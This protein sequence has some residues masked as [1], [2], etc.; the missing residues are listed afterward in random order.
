M[1]TKYRLA[2]LLLLTLGPA[3][4]IGRAAL[5]QEKEAIA[6]RMKK[7]IT[8]LASDECEGRGVGTLGL[9]LAAQYIAVQCSRAGLKPGGVNG[10]YFQPFPFCTGGQLDGESTLTINGPTKGKKRPLKQGE[11]F[12]VL[13]SSSSASLIRR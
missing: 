5:A 12:Q 6:E 3:G 2:L 10:T 8:F 4:L 1:L 11:D 9:D 7:D 13:G